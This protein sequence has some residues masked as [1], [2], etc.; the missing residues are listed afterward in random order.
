[1]KGLRKYVPAM[2]ESGGIAQPVT[3]NL[4]EKCIS[5]SGR[6]SFYA[7]L[8]AKVLKGEKNFH[9]LAKNAA[10]KAR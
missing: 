2:P 4:S 7:G 8:R 6:E 5:R 9:R 1:L 3:R 10:S